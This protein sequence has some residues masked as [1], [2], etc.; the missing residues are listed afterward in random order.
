MMVA[1]PE[2]LKCVRCQEMFDLHDGGSTHGPDKWMCGPCQP[3]FMFCGCE[4]L[5][6]FSRR[7]HGAPPRKDVPGWVDEID[8][9]AC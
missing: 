3:D 2:L 6:G 7:L 5:T 4:S 8:E 9:G 1:Q